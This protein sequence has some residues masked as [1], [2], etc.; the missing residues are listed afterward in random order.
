MKHLE[1]VTNLQLS[2]QNKLHIFTKGRE[3]TEKG[4]GTTDADVEEFT[5]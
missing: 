4:V 5:E 1:K 2:N 3:I